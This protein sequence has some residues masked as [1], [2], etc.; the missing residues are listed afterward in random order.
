MNIGRRISTGLALVGALLAFGFAAYLIALGPES[1]FVTPDG[2]TTTSRS[3]SLAG[4]VPLAIGVVAV[5]A[6]AKGRASGYWIA[7]AVAT[8]AAALFLFSISLQLAAIAVLLL[9]A[10]AARTLTTR[11]VRGR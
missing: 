1:T 10:A 6:V 3:P 11:A 2:P 7:A 4:L 9:V 8:V 5:W